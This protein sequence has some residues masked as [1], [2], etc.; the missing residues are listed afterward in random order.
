MMDEIKEKYG[1]NEELQN[2]LVARLYADTDSNPLA[3]CLPPL[4]Q[5]PVFIA[6][7]R[8]I[9]NL[10]NQKILGEAR[11]SFCSPTSRHFTLL[12]PV[13]RHERGAFLLPPLPRGPYLDRE[14]A[15]PYGPRHWLV[16]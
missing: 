2:A 6:L 1:K 10:A 15:T 14:A 9:L 7:Y 3:G 5:I 8:S 11:V 4:L 13:C 16:D 12:V